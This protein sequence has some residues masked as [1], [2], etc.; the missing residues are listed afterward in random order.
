MPI[1]FDRWIRSKLHGDDCAD[2]E[3]RRTLRSPVARG[4][5]PVLAS[6]EHDEGGARFGVALSRVEDG[7]L[8]A[9]GKVQCHPALGA[10][11]EQVSKPEIG[12]RSTAHHLVV[13]APRTV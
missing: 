8:L 4:A 6:G 3:K 5:G 12:E 13:A 11:S 2:P 1:R 9:V 10:G 7:H